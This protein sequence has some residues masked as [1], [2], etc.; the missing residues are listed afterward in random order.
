MTV[1]DQIRCG[2]WRRRKY[3]EVGRRRCNFFNLQRAVCVRGQKPKSVMRY[4]SMS[5][6]HNKPR[7]QKGKV[8]CIKA[9][10]QRPCT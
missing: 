7:C 2:S 10:V 1:L 6:S 9:Q 8:R 3:R 5:K 4:K